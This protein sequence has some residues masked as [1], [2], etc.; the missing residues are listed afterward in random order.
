M[1]VSDLSTRISKCTRAFLI[2]DT[3]IGVR[4][5]ASE[6]LEITREYFKN[7]F[8][9]LLKREK[10]AGDFLIHCGDVFDSRHSLNLFAMNLAIEIFEEISSI[11]P[12][13]IILG[14]HDIAKKNSND[15]H[16]VKV[17]KW[18]PNIQV[19]E[20]PRVIEISGKKFL[21]MPWRANHHEEL[22]CVKNNP[23]DFLFCHT[24]VQGLKFNKNTVIDEG[25]ELSQ[26]SS[27]RKVYAGHIHYAQCKNNFRMLGCP[28][29]MTRS[30][31]NNEKGVWCFDILKEEE[32][33]YPN[34][35]SP[36]FVRIIFEKVLEMQE[37]EARELFRNNFVDVLVDPK[38]SLNFPFGSF[39]DDMKGYRRLDFVPRLST[40]EDEDG[41]LLES[42]DS[43]MEKIDI[44]ELS[45]RI[46]QSTQH[47]D[48]IKDRLTST[49]KTL[50]ERVQKT[51]EE[52]ED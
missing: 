42:A 50:Y 47:S 14:N 41:K 49:I 5:S 29:P 28:Y 1:A 36:K 12:V 43:D 45:Q 6:W 20:E 37:E 33:Y 21:F 40:I 51:Q 17:L 31:I 30:D 39:S 8:I 4:N 13:V 2:T 44:I 15:V 27:F 46:I 38:W 23:A 48:H 19:L 16:S 11:L 18:I 35:I 3:H 22:E 7:F 32:I 24:D 10:R 34:T 9:P 52:K 25:I 26:L